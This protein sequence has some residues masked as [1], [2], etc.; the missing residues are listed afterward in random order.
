[1]MGEPETKVEKKQQQ[2][3]G[4]DSAKGTTDICELKG[5]MQ[6]RELPSGQ[7]KCVVTDES[8]LQM[9]PCFLEET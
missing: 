1:M 3:L 5:E 2:W 4:D 9:K 8:G 7:R 6:E